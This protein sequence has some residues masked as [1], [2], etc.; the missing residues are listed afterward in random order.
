MR[1]SP[2]LRRPWSLGLIRAAALT[3]AAAT[4]ALATSGATP[5]SYPIAVVPFTSVPVDGPLLVLANRHEPPG[6]PALRLQEERRR[7][8]YPELRA[9]GGPRA[10]ALRRQDALRRHGRLQAD[11][12]RV[13]FPPEPSRSRA[14]PLPRRDHR[15]DRRRP[16]ARRLPH[17]L[18]DDRRDEEP[19]LLAEAG[20]EVGSRAARAA[21]SSTTPAT[22]T[23][24]PTPTTGPPA[25]ETCSRSP[26][27]TRISSTARSAPD[28]GRTPPGHQIVETGLI[29]LAAVTGEARYSTLARFFLDQRGNAQGH[30]LHGPYNQDHLPVVEQDEAVGHAVR[31]AYM[32][33]AMVDVATLDDDAL[34]RTAVKRIWDD[35]VAHKLYLTGGLGARRD[36][37]GFGAAFE[38][39]NRSA[40]SETCA[41]IAN[42]YWNQRLFLQSGDSAYVDVLERSLYNAAIAGVSMG[43]D[44]FFYPNPLESD[45]HQPFNQG[46]LTRT[47][48]FDSSCCPTN[49]AR[50]L[51][52]VPD[53]VYAV[54]DDVLFVNLYVASTASATVGGGPVT[55]TQDTAYPWDRRRPRP[56]PAGRAARVRSAG[57]DSGLGPRTARAERAVPLRASPGA[58]FRR[59]GQRRAHDRPRRPRLRRPPPDLDGWRYRGRAPAHARPARPGARTGGGGPGQDRPRARPP[60]LLR[61]GVRQPGLRPRPRGSRRGGHSGRAQAGPAGRA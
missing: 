32:Y 7:G 46:A 9:G 11:R 20:P 22:S 24:R 42:V 28:G 47:P 61:G 56:D 44:A 23:R 30:E 49:V 14:R 53:Y 4:F 1:H 2:R 21:T 35:V 40:Y 57:A 31:A 41:S 25:G 60:R 27:R 33:S 50:F 36:N 45:G 18:Q 51:P 10:G 26:S 5:R 58:T 12:R 54:R 6:H 29:K 55:I 3:V 52:S 13:L 19:R 37:E 15:Q 17:D 16:G 8:P 48:W 43:G 59:R 34:Y 39:P 38:L